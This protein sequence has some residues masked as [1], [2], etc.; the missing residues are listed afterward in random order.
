MP[1]KKQQLTLEKEWEEFKTAFEMGC[2][3]RN[4]S[5]NFINA[6]RRL[7]DHEVD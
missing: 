7:R 1:Y 4:L 5:D 3:L 6:G 2:G